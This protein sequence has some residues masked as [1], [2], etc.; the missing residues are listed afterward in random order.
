MANVYTQLNIHLIFSV[1]KREC[2]LKDSFRNSVFKFIHGILSNTGNYPLTINGYKDHVH[3]FFELNPNN[4]ISEVARNVKANSSRWI[5]EQKFISFQFNWQRG[6]GAFS[7]SKS[8][9]ESVIR[10]IKEQ[11]NHHKRKTFKEEYLEFLKKYK[12]QFNEKY[13]FEWIDVK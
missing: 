10:Y 5:N 9:R 6:Y 3:A 7:Y 11:E 2:L 12:I 1:A 4:S 13:L 8:Q